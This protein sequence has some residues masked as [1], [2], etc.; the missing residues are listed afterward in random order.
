MKL[1]VMDIGSN[2]CR[3]LICEIIEP[4]PNKPNF[5]KLNLVRVPLRLGFDVF[6]T[7]A[8]GE[9]KIEELISTFQ[10][11]KYLLEAYDIKCYDACATSAMRDAANSNEVIERVKKATGLLIRVI[12]GKEEADTIF[13]NH[14]E[15]Y[16]DSTKPYLYI[17]VGGG[18][19]EL[20]LFSKEQLIF[21]ES[22][23]VGTIRMYKQNIKDEE[24]QRLKS[25]VK[26]ETKNYTNMVA[27]GSGGN[28]N[29][30][31]SMSKKKDGRPLPI[32][33]ITDYLAELSPLSIAERMSKYN[34]RED[35]ADVIVPALQIYSSVMRWANIQDI[36]VP[37]MGLVDGLMKNL[38]QKVKAS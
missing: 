26:N 11:Y 15:Q 29:K 24:W 28:I 3:L 12:S 1:A 36:H 21:E 2:A 32:S 18:S 38:Y 30:V 20:T 8:I 13:Q 25:F 35:R 7:G 37:Q 4:I 27:I 22:F 6:E 33:V 14:F 10:S 9:A 5:I 34:L 23:N 16:L 31:F 17:D 19:T